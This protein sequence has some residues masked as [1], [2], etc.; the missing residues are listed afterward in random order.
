MSGGV[1]L[2][3]GPKHMLSGRS[4]GYGMGQTGKLDPVGTSTSASHYFQ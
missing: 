4:A 2:A 1:G 3:A